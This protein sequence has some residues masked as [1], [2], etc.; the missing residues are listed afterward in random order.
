MQRI[1]P[2]LWF[3]DQAE[4]AARFYATIFRDSRIVHIARHGEAGREVHGKAPGTVMTQAQV[5]HYWHTLSADG[6]ERA[7]QCGWLKDKYG[8]RRLPAARRPAW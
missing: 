5:D 7:Q 6:D 8:V 1:T 4:E 3:D 2:C